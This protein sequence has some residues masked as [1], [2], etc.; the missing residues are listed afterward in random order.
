MSFGEVSCP[1]ISTSK[2]SGRLFQRLHDG[3]DCSRDIIFQIM[4][5]AFSLKMFRSFDFILKLRIDLKNCDGGS[6]KQ[7]SLRKYVMYGEKKYV[8]GGSYFI[9]VT[10]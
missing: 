5:S 6:G 9:Y 10:L 3:E 1:K 7:Q 4:L 8:S 2:Q